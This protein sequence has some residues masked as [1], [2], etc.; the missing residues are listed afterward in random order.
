MKFLEKINELEARNLPLPIQQCGNC[1]D[2][3]YRLENWFQC[4]KCGAKSTQYGG[5]F[6]NIS[7]NRELVSASK[8]WVELCK[9]SKDF[10]DKT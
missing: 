4:P 3:I 8:E 5:L 2:T 6:P 7:L 1:G 9:Q 10:F